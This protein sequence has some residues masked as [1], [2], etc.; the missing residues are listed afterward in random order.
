MSEGSAEIRLSSP[1]GLAVRLLTQGASWVG[2]RV[3]L[4][5]GG[6]RELRLG[7]DSLEE[8]RANQV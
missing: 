8:H 6:D 5:D 7:F 1:D 2:C 4:R 3:P